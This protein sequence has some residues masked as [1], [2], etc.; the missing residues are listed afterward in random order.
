MSAKDLLKYYQTETRSV[1]VVSKREFDQ[2][3]MIECM[4]I[5][6]YKIYMIESFKSVMINIKT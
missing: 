4:L 2:F 6:T 1:L 3:G 5:T